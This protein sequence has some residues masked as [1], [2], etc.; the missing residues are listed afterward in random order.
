MVREL[1]V[2]RL[3]GDDVVPVA[4]RVD[5]EIDRGETVGLAGPS[6]SGKTATALA[7][8]GLHPGDGRVRVEGSVRFRGRELVGLPDT[9]WPAV[10]GD[11]IGYIPQDPGGS[12]TPVRRVGDLIAEVLRTH[13]ERDDVS[14][15]RVEAAL[16]EVGFDNPVDVARRYPHELSGGMQ[17]RVAIAAA[18]AG[19]PDLLIADEPTSSLDAIGRTTTLALLRRIRQSRGMGMLLIS[20]DR[21]ELVT[22][23]DR[24]VETGT[25]DR[26]LPNR[27]PPGRLDRPGPIRLSRSGAGDDPGPPVIDLREVEVRFDRAGPD[28]SSAVDGVSLAV[29]AGESIGLVGPNGCGKTTLVLAAMRLVNPS[30]GRILIE[31]TDVTGISERRIRPLRA[32]IGMVFQ[33]PAASINPRMDAGSVIGSPLRYRKL[34]TSVERRRLVLEVAD[35]VGLHE[36]LLGRRPDQLSGGENQRVAI[37]RALVCDPA[38]L[39]LDEPFSALDEE[40]ERELADLL[41]ELREARRLATL[42][43]SHDLGVVAD[44]TER[45]VVMDKGRIVEDGPTL[46]L[47]SSPRAGLTRALLA[48]TP[49][50]GAPARD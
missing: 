28:A 13:R 43:I 25:A 38:V 23:V 4:G 35:A 36:S 18:L 40:S 15:T 5:L 33:S 31:G 46:T 47:V 27:Q 19:D 22:Q 30:A 42:F 44:I 11:G 2:S 29:G 14:G 12:L 41:V 6:G 34:G 48:A 21:R 8:L 26:P 3:D 17:Q 1:K 32:R 9:D 37:A 49:G 50:L 45:L 20:H 7:I 39:I 24:L 10:R 16:R